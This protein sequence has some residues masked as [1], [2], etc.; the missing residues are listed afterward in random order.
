MNKIFIIK[1]EFEYLRSLE[2][3][4]PTL[5]IEDAYRFKSEILANKYSKFLNS[6]D[7]QNNVINLE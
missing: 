7:I 6:L 1:L 4:L 3:M 2:S 5:K